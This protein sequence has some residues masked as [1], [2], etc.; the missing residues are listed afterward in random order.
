L[1][2]QNLQHFGVLIS[3]VLIVIALGQVYVASDRAREA[4][5]AKALSDQALVRISNAESILVSVAD[6]LLE[7]L[8]AVEDGIAETTRAQ[9]EIFTR[10][11]ERSDDERVATYLGFTALRLKERLEAA[12]ERGDEIR[13]LREQLLSN[14]SQARRERAQ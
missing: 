10:N 14:W 6:D 9:I 5:D 2:L 4:S 13:T 8:V 3:L 7:Q 1:W 12:T 11:A